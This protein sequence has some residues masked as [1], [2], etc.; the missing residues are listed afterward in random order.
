MRAQYTYTKDV[1]PYIGWNYEPYYEEPTSS[2]GGYRYASSGSGGGGSVEVN[3]TLTSGRASAG[4]VQLIQEGLG[5]KDSPLKEARENW[6]KRKK[7]YEKRYQMALAYARAY[8]KSVRDTI[9]K[10]DAQ[11]QELLAKRIKMKEDAVK[12]IGFDALKSASGIKSDYGK[13]AAKVSNTTSSRGLSSA[14]KSNLKQGVEREQGESLNRLEDITKQREL[15]TTGKLESAI[16]G[17]MERQLGYYPDGSEYPAIASQF[18][19]SAQSMK[20]MKEPDIPDD[21]P[22]WLKTAL[23]VISLYGGASTSG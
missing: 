16:Q 4:S 20:G 8:E 1:E 9:E 18:Y 13:A 6:K 2:G 21:A 7:A 12:R 11:Y 5:M 15:S 22:G 10:Q 23:G 14:V 17:Y 19:Q 3:D